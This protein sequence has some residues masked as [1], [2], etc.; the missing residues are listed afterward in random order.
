MEGRIGES[1]LSV[2]N[3]E[4]GM[5]RSS[6]DQVKLGLRVWMTLGDREVSRDLPS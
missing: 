5:R 3:V 2:C 1:E 6:L 4:G